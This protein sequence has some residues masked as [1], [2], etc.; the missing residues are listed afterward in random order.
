[1]SSNSYIECGKIINTHGCYGGLKLESWCNTPEELAMLK[2]LYIKK[3]GEFL[4]CSVDKASVFKQFVIVT[5]NNVKSMDEALALK[6]TV[7]YALRKDFRLEE[8]FEAKLSDQ[9]LLDYVNGIVSWEDARE[10]IKVEEQKWIRKA[11]KFIL[12]DDQPYR[13]K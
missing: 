6:N 13:I 5:L 12:Y 11:K 2:K 10:H 3:D 4:K 1:M 9:L 8:G 7:V